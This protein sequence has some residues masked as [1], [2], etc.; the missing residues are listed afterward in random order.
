MSWG[1]SVQGMITSLR[2]NKN[3]VP[4]RKSLY[5]KDKRKNI[6]YAI[7]EGLNCNIEATEEQLL[8]IRTRIQ[9]RNKRKRILNSFIITISVVFVLYLS[10]VNSLKEVLVQPTAVIETV[11]DEQV[12]LNYIKYG[13]TWF[14]DKKWKA[15][16]Y[17]YQKAVD[18]A[19]ND[20]QA[21]YKLV[22]AYSYHCTYENINCEEGSQL[23]NELITKFGSNSDIEYLL[24][25]IDNR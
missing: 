24:E 23:L 8:E 20:Y 10:Y 3:L 19:P 14:E 25:I 12:Y 7:S 16:I 17:N 18:L 4:K 22:I 9:K 15:A 5:E 2:N 13:D 1:G 11:N 6:N 21:Q